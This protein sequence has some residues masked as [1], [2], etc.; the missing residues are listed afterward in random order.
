[1]VLSRNYRKMLILKNQME[2]KI[3]LNKWISNSHNMRIRLRVN[4]QISDRKYY[5]LSWH[6]DRFLVEFLII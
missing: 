2:P 5:K 3:L 1:M 6:V 4:C